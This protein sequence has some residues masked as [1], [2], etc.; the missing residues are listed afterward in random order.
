MQ[1]G[2]VNRPSMEEWKPFPLAP[3]YEISTHGRIRKVR[4]GK[5]PSPIRV[6]DDNNG[7]L[8][9]RLVV[10]GYRK[11]YRVHRLV[12]LTWLGPPPTPEHSD[13]AHADGNGCNNQLSN[14][15]WATRSENYSD[16]IAH[17]RRNRQLANSHQ[18][19]VIEI[20][21]FHNGKEVTCPD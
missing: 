1:P 13:V 8:C 14:L 5:P 2:P 16:K 9:T 10:D 15:R 12:A 4:H 21:I 18:H 11:F 7:Y 20:R 17:S 3:R 19:L 6:F